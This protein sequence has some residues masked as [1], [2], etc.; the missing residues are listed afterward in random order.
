MPEDVVETVA[1]PQE[2]VL[3]RQEGERLG[4]HVCC[5]PCATADIERLAEQW[6]VEAVWHN[7]NI[8]PAEEYQRRLE[9]MRTVA[10]RTGTPL[11]VLECNVEEW[12]ELCANLMDEPEDGA[13][14][15]VCFRMRLEAT[16][17]WAQE[18]GIEVITT[19]LT[20]SP[21]KDADRIN[22]IGAEVAAQHSLRWLERDFKKRGGFQ[23][24][25]ELSKQMDLYRQDYCG[26]LPSRG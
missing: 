9:G 22:E 13:R 16:V 1:G 5:G 19:T 2:S 3:E 25:V 15:E 26:C 10:E 6:Q 12:Q 7:P 17:R 8:Q 23:R 21:H 24:S 11:T 14:C 18:E 20:V 4:L